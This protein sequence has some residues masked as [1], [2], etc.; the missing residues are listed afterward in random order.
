LPRA[1]AASR[2]APATTRLE[3]LPP[4]PGLEE[5]ERERLP[6]PVRGGDTRRDQL[7]RFLEAVEHGQQ[8]AAPLSCDP[9]AGLLTGAESVAHGLLVDCQRV[10]EVAVDITQR[11]L[12]LP[13]DRARRE[14]GRAVD[15]HPSLLELL[16][17]LHRPPGLDQVVRQPCLVLGAVLIGQIAQR[18]GPPPRIGAYVRRQGEHAGQTEEHRRLLGGRNDIPQALARERLGVVGLAGSV[19]QHRCGRDQRTSSWMTSGNQVQSA[20]AQ[21]GRRRRIARAER[22]RGVLEQADRHLVTRLGAG[23]QLRG[24][25]DRNRPGREQNVD[26]LPIQCPARGYRRAVPNGFADD[27]VAKAE[28]VGA[29]SEHA[30]LD[31]LLDRGEQRCGRSSQHRRQLPDGETTTERGGR[32]GERRADADRRASRWRMPAVTRL[33][34]RAS[35]SL[36]TPSSMRMGRLSWRGR[37]GVFTDPARCL[38]QLRDNIMEAGS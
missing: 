16:G 21:F 19:Q 32:D 22:V 38:R 1:R 4:A 6:L 36:A 26:G 2:R 10:R 7:Q 28:L 15:R 34:S 5:V 8:F 35:N 14:V 31:Q 24:D 12:R 25:L 27:V 18:Q 3:Q 30:G 17:R 9:L 29:L 20:A 11:P 33:G 13:Q 23:G 37:R